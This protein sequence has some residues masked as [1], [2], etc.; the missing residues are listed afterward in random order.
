[1]NLGSEISCVL[2]DGSQP[3]SNAVGPVLEVRE[4]M[5]VLEKK[6]HPS[7]LVEKTVGIAG[8]L[9]ELSGKSNKAD[10]DLLGSGKSLA[11]FREIIGA[12]R[13]D[14]TISAD[15]IPVG[16]FTA[17]VQAPEKGYTCSINSIIIVGIARASGAPERSGR[18]NHHS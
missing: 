9:L 1:M 4:A 10:E 13:G 3:V 12:Q 15:A 6:A 5:Y 8:A 11:E 16:K 17:P 7:T 18:R 14:A 2:T